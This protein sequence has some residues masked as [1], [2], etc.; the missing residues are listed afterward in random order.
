MPVGVRGSDARPSRSAARSD[1][2]ASA[3]DRR[4]G[5]RHCRSLHDVR[6]PA[7]RAGA[8]SLPVVSLSMSCA[9]LRAPVVPHG[10]RLAPP[11]QPGA[12]QRQNAASAAASGRS[13]CPRPCRPSPPSAGCRSDST[14]AD[15]PS[16]AAGRAATCPPPP[17]SRRRTGR[18]H[19]PPGAG[20]RPKPSAGQLTRTA[21]PGSMARHYTSG[22]GC[23]IWRALLQPDGAHSKENAIRQPEATLLNLV[24]Q[25]HCPERHVRRMVRPNCAFSDRVRRH[26][27]RPSTASRSHSSCSPAPAGRGRS[28]SP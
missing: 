26:F 27:R 18:H 1:R 6:P 28:E 13:A 5:R 9:G 2:S 20:G 21:K 10:D 25:P 19:T 11:D 4:R 8:R 7:R 17:E 14:S 23:D 12:A 24:H 3:A 15:R 16:L 22:P